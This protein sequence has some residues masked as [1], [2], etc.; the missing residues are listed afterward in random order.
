MNA[1]KESPVQENPLPW[2]PFWS[3]TKSASRLGALM[4]SGGNFSYYL[5]KS[6]LCFHGLSR[7]LIHHT[8][9]CWTLIKLTKPYDGQPKTFLG[10]NMPRVTIIESYFIP[11]RLYVLRYSLIGLW[12]WFVFMAATQSNAFSLLWFFAFHSGQVLEVGGWLTPLRWFLASLEGKAVFL[13]ALAIAGVGTSALWHLAKKG[14]RITVTPDYVQVG[15]R[16]FGKRYALA[17]C[18]VA[19]RPH[20]WASWEKN[21]EEKRQREAQMKGHK[22]LPTMP[23][24]ARKSFQ[25]VLAQEGQPRLLATIYGEENAE[26]FVT[27]LQWAIDQMAALEPETDWWRLKRKWAGLD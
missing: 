2:L 25:A 22:R 15:S 6:R 13:Q 26:A 21:R 8:K 4:P 14:N 19:L 10:W 11:W 16:I 27:R 3:L 18:K 17:S 1:D 7:T 5:E 9:N 12:S 24:Y 23:Q 20:P